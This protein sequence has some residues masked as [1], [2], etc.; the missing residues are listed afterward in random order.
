[1]NSN[2]ILNTINVMIKEIKITNFYVNAQLDSNWATVPFKKCAYIMIGGRV[3]KNDLEE[4]QEYVTISANEGGAFSTEWEHS[5]LKLLF[6]L[7]E[8]Y[9]LKDSFFKHNDRGGHQMHKLYDDNAELY[10][11]P[12]YRNIVKITYYA[13]LSLEGIS[14][15]NINFR[16]KEV[17]DA[18]CSVFRSNAAVISVS[19]FPGLAFKS[20]RTNLSYLKEWIE[21][22]EVQALLKAKIEEL[23]PK[24][25]YAAFDLGWVSTYSHLF[26]WLKGRT[27]KELV[28]C[29]GEQMILDRCVVSGGSVEGCTYAIDKKGVLWVQGIHP[30]A[31]LSH[32]RMRTFATT[33]WQW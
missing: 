6:I 20:T 2:N 10:S 21:I 33:L 3:I 28:D 9:I 17:W 12:M 29:E 24:R 14:C 13:Y 26:G 4:G 25:I 11:N 30:S 16:Q 31:R 5:K 18:A 1:M 22:P 23:N 19:P 32:A 27:L 7:R 8:S 15:E